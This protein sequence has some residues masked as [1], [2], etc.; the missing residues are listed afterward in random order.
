MP[1]PEQK[2]ILLLIAWVFATYLLFLCFREIELDQAWNSIK[3]V[4][5][6][7]LSLGIIGHFLIFIFWAKQWIIFLPGKTS[8]TFKEM[9]KINALMST[10]MNIL[11]FPGGHAFGVFLLAKKEGV[12]HSTALSVM[13]LDQLTEGIAKL[14]VLL[15]ASLFTPIPPLMKTGI[16]VLIVIIF[17][18]MSILIY[19]SYR[20]HDYKKKEASFKTTLK[21]KI[22]DFVSRWGHQLEGLRNFR[23]FFYGVILAYGM[24]LGEASAIFAIQMGFD[25][26]LPIWSILLVLSALNLTTVIP[27]VPGN[28]GVYEATVF[29]VYQYLG[30]EPEQAIALALTQHLCFLL[31]LAGTGYLYTLKKIFTTKKLIS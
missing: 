15:T 11:P 2:K 17:L 29:F 1:S 9:F 19:F 10:A 22:I 23:V 21:E 8:I 25:V 16:L 30:I 14:T 26:D 13:S 12:D 7:W 4:H 20:F 6:L 24:K 3:K 28:L 27:L 5:P 18:F 31:P